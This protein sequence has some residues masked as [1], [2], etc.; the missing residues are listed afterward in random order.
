MTNNL[1]ILLLTLTESV[2]QYVIILLNEAGMMNLNLNRS[3]TYIVYAAILAVAIIFASA[4][5]GKGLQ[6]LK[7]MTPVVTVKGIAERDVLSDL[8]IWEI[9]YREI[10]N[11][12]PKLEELIQRDY[13]ASIKFLK[14]QG[15]RAEDIEKSSFKIEDR[16]AN[17]YL[18]NQPSTPEANRY[19]VT[20][21]I[22]IR[23]SNV[24]LI[25]KTSQILDQLLQQGVPIAFDV[26]AMSPNPSYYYTKLDD[27]RPKMMS[28]ATKSAYLV[29]KQFAY[30]SSSRLDGIQRANQGLFQVMGRDTST[31]S[32]DWN[33]GQSALSSI[34]KKIRLVST[35]DYRLKK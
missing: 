3:T 30:D 29:A 26:S 13:D 5:I 28:D 10:G 14:Q 12:L 23:S 35:I 33:N 11:D 21:G 31:L 19:I 22:R 27:I 4:K 18:Q 25:R 1:K 9:N 8:G 34:E 2:R 20:A 7:N 16:L 17:M 15:F 24:A 6:F 32:A